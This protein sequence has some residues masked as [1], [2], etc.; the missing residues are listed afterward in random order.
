MNIQQG[1]GP[2]PTAL[3]LIDVQEGFGDQKW[4]TRNN[5]EAEKNIA[6]ILGY[7]RE[8]RQPVI[9]IQHQS[10]ELNS[11]LHPD[12]PGCEFKPEARPVDGELI[13]RKQVNSAFIGTGL[14]QH[15]RVHNINRLVIVGLTT[16]HC[17]STT[18]RMAGNLG[19]SAILVS[20]ASA[21]F[22]REALDGI[23]IP[24]EDIHRIHLASLNGEF[25]QILSTAEVLSEFT[26]SL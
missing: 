1:L 23:N 11:P 4:G 6:V 7:W 26:H 3:I 15:L 13:F 19:F 5:H 20:D 25:C 17:V 9:H 21:T 8:L 24:A 18:V 14:E 12:A 22:N 2:G 10:T 16:D